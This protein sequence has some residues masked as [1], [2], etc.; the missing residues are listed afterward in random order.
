MI[1]VICRQAEPVDGLTLVAFERGE[2]R[3]L[4]K[5]VPARLCPGCGEAYVDEEITEQLLQIASLNGLRNML[6]R[7]IT[8]KH[9]LNGVDTKDNVGRIHGSLFL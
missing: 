9:S 2:F 5:N 3:L 6:H 1:C 7:N 4:V 8:F